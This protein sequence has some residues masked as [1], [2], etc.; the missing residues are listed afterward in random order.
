MFL[1]AKNENINFNL[2]NKIVKAVNLIL[3]GYIYFGR[4]ALCDEI[5][6]YSKTFLGLVMK[7]TTTNF[8][9]KCF[10]N[11]ISELHKKALVLSLLA[12]KDYE[13]F[14]DFKFFGVFIL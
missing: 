5:Y 14:Y 3:R 8:R 2:K 11:V 12:D 10:E 6:T 1:K 7:T 4:Y 13:Y 9:E